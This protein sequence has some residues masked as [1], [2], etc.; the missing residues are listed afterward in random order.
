MTVLLLCILVVAFIHLPTGILL[1]LLYF[2]LAQ[3]VF[4]EHPH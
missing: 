2:G 1:G 3:H 4:T